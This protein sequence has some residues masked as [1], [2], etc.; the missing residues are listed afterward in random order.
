MWVA[1][2]QTALLALHR[3]APSLSGTGV[4]LAKLSVGTGHRERKSNPD[5]TC[6]K[7]V[8]LADQGRACFTVSRK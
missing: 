3:S 8:G 7:C 4:A 2:V 5:C 6:N 1:W